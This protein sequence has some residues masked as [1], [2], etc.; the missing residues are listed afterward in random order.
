MLLILRFLVKMF[1]RTHGELTLV[2]TALGGQQR[3]YTFLFTHYRLSLNTIRSQADE[4]D[5]TRMRLHTCDTICA[6][7]FIFVMH[8]PQVH[9][10]N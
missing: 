1:H 3:R 6:C 10:L 7:F 9:E 5:D 2:S 8:T 4:E